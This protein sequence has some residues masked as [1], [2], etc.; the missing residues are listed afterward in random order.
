M[1]NMKI[2]SLIHTFSTT[3]PRFVGLTPN[4][5]NPTST[6][7]LTVSQESFWLV[8]VDVV[9]QSTRY[10]RV[11]NVVRW[12]SA[13]SMSNIHD[14]SYFT[15]SIHRDWGVITFYVVVMTT[16]VAH[17]KDSRSSLDQ[18]KTR[19]S[20]ADIVSIQLLAR[21]TQAAI[22]RIYIYILHSS[23]NHLDIFKGK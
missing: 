3:L 21:R 12:H 2:S 20:T 11:M 10:E 17:L 19:L 14:S 13:N 6:S 22:R 1:S 23:L 18:S 16:A 9:S 5:N 8:P 4:C 7:N 15:L